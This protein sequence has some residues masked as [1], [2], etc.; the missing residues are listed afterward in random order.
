MLILLWPFCTEVQVGPRMSNKVNAQCLFENMGC[1][2]VTLKASVIIFIICTIMVFL[3]ISGNYTT[4]TPKW[5]WLA[6]EL[7]ILYNKNRYIRMKTPDMHARAEKT[8]KEY[9]GNSLYNKTLLNFRSR[10]PTQH[11]SRVH[12]LITLN[13][14]VWKVQLI[15]TYFLKNKENGD[16]SP[17]VNTETFTP[18]LYQI[19]CYFVE[20]LTV[21]LNFLKIHI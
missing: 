4:R 1:G 3:S 10:A 7:R 8:L 13:T 12:L 15:L 2:F 17:M 6:K 21:S 20:T 9:C 11:F 19:K 5:K 14:P 18:C 16:N